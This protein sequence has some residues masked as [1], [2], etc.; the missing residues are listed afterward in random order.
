MH[1]HVERGNDEAKFWL[2]DV[3]SLVYNFGFRRNEITEIRKQ[4]FAN[5]SRIERK[6]HEHFSG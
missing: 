2:D 6:W 3:M 5:R 1:V 4:I